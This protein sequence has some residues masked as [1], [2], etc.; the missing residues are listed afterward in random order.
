[1]LRWG[2]NY[3][4]RRIVSFEAELCFLAVVPDCHLCLTY[5]MVSGRSLI[6]DSFF[7]FLYIF[8][9]LRNNEKEN[10]T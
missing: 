3:I 10:T 4:L 2:G 1:M 7:Q 9:Y 5:E 6:F 8:V